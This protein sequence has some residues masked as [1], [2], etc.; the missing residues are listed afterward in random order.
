MFVP[1]SSWRSYLKVMRAYLEEEDDLR[2][3]LRALVDPKVP[4]TVAAGM[5]SAMYPPEGQLRIREYVPHAKIV[6]F[7]RSGHVPMLDEPLLF[8]RTLARFLAS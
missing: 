2:P 6:R 8:Q 4:V 5:R 7:E 1:G 3:G